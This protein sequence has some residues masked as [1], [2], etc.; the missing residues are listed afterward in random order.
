MH[1][2]SNVC[3]D[4]WRESPIC[5]SGHEVAVRARRAR[6]DQLDLGVGPHL[7]AQ[8]LGRR[9][10]VRH[11]RVLGPEDAA[12]VAPLGLDAAAEVDR[13]RNAVAGVPGRRE[14]RCPQ[15]ARLRHLVPGRALH[16]QSLLGARVVGVERGAVDLA[17]PHAPVGAVVRAVVAALE[18][19]AGGAQR[20]GQVE[21]RAS[22]NPVAEHDLG[23]EALDQP[24][25][26]RQQLDVHRLP[27]VRMKVALP[28]L[29]HED[30]GLL[31]SGA[32][33]LGQAERRD[34]PA[35]ARADD[36]D[37]DPHGRLPDAVRSGERARR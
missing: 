23:A 20:R 5:G 15:P 11:H 7:H 27:E 29:E 6:C 4:G 1:S 32:V 31:A 8:L 21:V 3:P 16:A 2:T 35:E 18:R 25:E 24:V 26:P 14:P 28:A 13:L 9:Q 33:E 19:L 34:R 37:V 10:V 36:A 12:G 22:T 30:A 17:R